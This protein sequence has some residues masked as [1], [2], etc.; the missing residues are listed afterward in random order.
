VLT[1]VANSFEA[2]SGPA[3]PDT[4]SQVIEIIAVPEPTGGDVVVVQTPEFIDMSTDVTAVVDIRPKPEVTVLS[5]PQSIAE[6]IPVIL[7]ELIAAVEYVAIE[8]D[9][10]DL[11]IEAADVLLIPPVVTTT[12]TFKPLPTK[13]V[14]E[15]DILAPVDT[16]ESEKIKPII[17]PSGMVQYVP[18][19]EVALSPVA[20]IEDIVIV[21]NITRSEPESREEL[22]VA[23]ESIT[24]PLET[25]I[26]REE[27]METLVPLVQEVVLSEIV[28][29]PQEVEVTDEL[30][31]PS[32]PFPEAIDAPSDELVT[33]VI[34]DLENDEYQLEQAVNELND[35]SYAR[36]HTY[37]TEVSVSGELREVL[38]VPLIDSDTIDPEFRLT[39]LA[40]QHH[41]AIQILHNLASQ[42]LRGLIILSKHSRTYSR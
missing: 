29:L 18:E 25:V 3:Q 42:A 40:A 9:T 14:T 34:K 6:S 24:A 12:E 11:T 22:T 35:I 37:D 16:D 4:R 2:T 33:G 28:D 27:V 8:T 39:N 26:V 7:P 41:L 32:I 38:D 13:I 21:Q 1:V 31:S 23:T 17:T 10:P 15:A 30:D 36:G 20:T 5:T 19:I